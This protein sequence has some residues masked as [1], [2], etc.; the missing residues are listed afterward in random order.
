VP[1]AYEETETQVYDF[2]ENDPQAFQT[3]TLQAGRFAALPQ[4]NCRV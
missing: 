1:L 4:T 3:L 2:L